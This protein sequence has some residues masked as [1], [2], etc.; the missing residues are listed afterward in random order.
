MKKIVYCLF[1]LGVI[2]SWGSFSVFAADRNIPVF[3]D[4]TPNNGK[5][6]GVG[7]N[8]MLF[9]IFSTDI[10]DEINYATDRFISIS[11]E[12]TKDF[13]LDFFMM[14][15][16]GR[17]PTH[18]LSIELSNTSYADFTYNRYEDNIL[19][20]VE[21]Q[22]EIILTEE[23][24]K[25]TINDNALDN[26]NKMNLIIE[27][28]NYNY[29]KDDTYPT[30]SFSL[31]GKAVGITH[32]T[33][34]VTSNLDGYTDIQE[35]SISLMINVVDDVSKAIPQIP[36]DILITVSNI[37]SGTG[38]LNINNS[39]V[40]GILTDAFTSFVIT[41]PDVVTSYNAANANEIY[42]RITGGSNVSITDST[43]INFLLTNNYNAF[44]T[45]NYYIQDSES[46]E[47][48]LA[49]YTYSF[50][51]YSKSQIS[52]SY[53]KPQN[54]DSS[55]PTYLDG[56]PIIITTTNDALRPYI[57]DV[58]VA[59][60]SDNN[61]YSS[62]EYLPFQNGYPYVIEKTFFTKYVT[63]C[64]LT[65]AKANLA[66]YSGSIY[67]GALEA[68]EFTNE[69]VIEIN[70]PTEIKIDKSFTYQANSEVSATINI[71][72]IVDFPSNTS[73]LVKSNGVVSASLNLDK[74]INIYYKNDDGVSRQISDTITIIASL[75]NGSILTKDVT[76][77]I[78]PEDSNYYTFDKLEINMRAGETE[79][80]TLGYNNPFFTEAINNVVTNIFLKCNFVEVSLQPDMIHYDIYA[81]TDGDESVYFSIQDNRLVEV[82]IH[83]D[84]AM[85]DDGIEEEKTDYTFDSLNLSMV[86]GTT[87]TITL[88][89]MKNGD[90]VPADVNIIE[91]NF[92]VKNNNVSV[93]NNETSYI[94]YDIK[95]L[96]SG[97]DT[98]YFIAG[99]KI[100]EVTIVIN[101][102][103][104]TEN[105]NIDFAEGVFLSVFKD[106]KLELNIS[107]EYSHLLF[108]FVNVNNN[109]VKFES[110]YS[111]R[112]IIKGISSGETQIFAL[113][114]FDFTVYSAVITIRVIEMPSLDLIITNKTNNLDNTTN[115]D[116][117]S[118]SFFADNFNFSSTAS[119][120]WYFNDVVKYQNIESF[121]Q[122]LAPGDYIVRLVITDELYDIEVE[123]T[124][125][126]KVTKVKNESIQFDFMEGI[127]ITILKNDTLGVINVPEIYSSL[128]FTFI[129]LD[130]S[131]VSIED[132][133]NNK[134]YIKGMK[135]GE[136][137][138]FGY[139]QEDNITYSGVITIKVI[140]RIPNVN[141]LIEKEQND[142]TSLTIYDKLTISFDAENFDFSKATTFDWYI[143][144][145]LTYQNI[146]SFETTFVE[147]QYE[148]KLLINDQV[149]SLNIESVQNIVITKVKNEERNIK[150]NTDDV[151]YIDLNGGDFQIDVLLD[152][153][154]NPTYKYIWSVDN[155][156]ICR[157]KLNGNEKVILSPNYIGETTLTVMTNISKYEEIYIKSEI[158]IVVINPTYTIE[159]QSYIKPNTSQKF[160]ILGN[161]K[162]IYNASPRVSMMVNG[163]EFS[164]Y[165]IVGSEIIINEIPKGNYSINL[166]INND[167]K[168]KSNFEVSSFN[169]REVINVIL[170][171]LLVISFIVLAIAFIVKKRKTKLER[172]NIR[173]NKLN[174]LIDSLLGAENI[175]KR[176]IAKLN[177]Q[178]NNLQK[179]LIYCID[180]GIDEI[181]SLIPTV[182]KLC[183]IAKA[184]RNTVLSNEKNIQ[185]I[186]N[187]KT[188]IMDNLLKDFRIIKE[189]RDVF[190]KR[191]VDD[192][193]PQKKQKNIKV[194]ENYEEYLIKTKYV[195]ADDED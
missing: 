46:N 143:N 130:E 174:A 71:E 19:K 169:I 133:E 37:A 179:F 23:S 67:A 150:I 36:S 97:Y 191:H 8:N 122:S 182:E 41:L 32:I 56:T 9:D 87:Q 103:I 33:F 53:E 136:T 145:N 83:I 68:F 4:G 194:K 75:A 184:M 104:V 141:I 185:I 138:L 24:T 148:I 151:I 86:V 128:S 84:P 186:N 137:Q 11:L 92:I 121:E 98:V 90:F 114:S 165:E 100:I 161:G 135:E 110:V 152:G 16:Y 125:N 14:N 74:S 34:T 159:G 131:I 44:F 25:K 157:I 171:Y 193:I 88:G 112:V 18:K 129:V 99:T 176:D 70:Y 96:S 76:I 178:A 66:Y 126:I 127:H 181:K 39:K 79:T 7:K 160:Q 168:L 102:D 3:D 51:L 55:N 64:D 81:I 154:L 120:K 119:I 2:F 82:K 54:Y 166:D 190:D 109:V 15:W 188:R 58:F 144:G 69:N 62:Y 142:L 111:N 170:P 180:E 164:D 195:N 30:L 45:I 95:A 123:A 6:S 175:T 93:S 21:E 94:K 124:K 116:T 189:E 38:Y 149:N 118:F 105:V 12:E 172:A 65:L 146:K 192:D 162:V 1:L 57:E 5:S 156:T 173:L 72:N 52:I 147:G 101:D 187:I 73:F 139:S 78:V 91:S 10:N 155:Q 42:F 35:D 49:S 20:A 29:Y 167:N 59:I 28:D 107:P 26:Y 117:L 177:R 89:Y 158:K 50:V 163:E 113:S 77:N 106:E 13:S 60:E 115:Y 43:K 108:N 47:F 40:V 140:E 27:N 134:L 48:L 183:M 80:I 31:T 85:S 22:E 63:I 61:S 17:Y 132:I 153:V